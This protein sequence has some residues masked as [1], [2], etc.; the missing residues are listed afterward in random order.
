MDAIIEIGIEYLST[1]VWRKKLKKKDSVATTER[2]I[3]RYFM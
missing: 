1:T 3:F 2:V